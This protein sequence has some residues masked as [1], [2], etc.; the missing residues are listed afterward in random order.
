MDYYKDIIGKEFIYIGKYGGRLR[1]RCKNVSVEETILV[2]PESEQ[3]IKWRMDQSP[4]GTGKIE[5]PQ[6]SDSPKYS[7][8][9]ITRFLISEEGNSYEE[10]SCYIID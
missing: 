6:M 1:M 4:K 9:K 8:R 3:W 5:K 10:E 2:D 7:A